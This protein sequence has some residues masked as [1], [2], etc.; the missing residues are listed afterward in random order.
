MASSDRPLGYGIV[1]A[2]YFGAELARIIHALPTAHVAAVFS[3]EDA[4]ALATEVGCDVVGSVAELV[5]RDDVDVVVIAS[6]NDVHLEPALLAAA[7][8][9]HVFC[10]KPVAL[11]YADADA[12]VTAC[13]DAGVL[14]MAGHVMH[15]MDG[16]RRT[17]ELVAAGEIGDV[18]LARAAR[19]GWVD[20]EHESPG[21]PSWKRQ[22]ARSGG[23]LFHHI[24]E[25]DVVQLLLGPAQ[26]V[27]MAGGNVAHQGTAADEDDLLLATL[28]HGA[29]RFSHLEWGSAYRRPEHYV[30][31]F[32]TR[33]TVR[34]DFQ[35][36]GVEVRTP[37]SV[38]R[39]PLHRSEAE[40]AERRDEYGA[41]RSGGGVDYGNPAM[42]PPGWLIGIMEREVAYLHALLRGEREPDPLL[43]G[44][45]DGHAARAS[46]ATAEALTRS[47]AQDRKV[48]V[49]EVRDAEPT[50]RED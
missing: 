28:E 4:S 7:H 18:L 38:T 42:R 44:L 6:P 8:G 46:I 15:F 29:G 12:M 49:S 1:G 20:D 37:D 36:V 5:A 16:V 21:T 19:T 35:D 3:P 2:G 13:A 24:H 27:V 34:I 43:A 23:H 32:G 45:T 9:K 40:D 11:S 22:R 30:E 33:G 41:S 10:E 50:A 48:S 25:L 31:L 39:F 47:L 26:R 17:A 14:F